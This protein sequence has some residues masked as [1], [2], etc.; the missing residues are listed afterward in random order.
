MACLEMDRACKKEVFKRM[1]VNWKG[2]VDQALDIVEDLNLE[3][4]A[5]GYP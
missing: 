1:G 3:G 2:R 5:S 4:A